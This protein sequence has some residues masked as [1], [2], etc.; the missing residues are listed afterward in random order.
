MQDY[1][2]LIKISC[3]LAPFY[4]YKVTSNGYTYILA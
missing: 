4:S 2:R 3:N 1:M